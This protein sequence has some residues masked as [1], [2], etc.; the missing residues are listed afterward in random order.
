MNNETSQYKDT[1]SQ[2]HDSLDRMEKRTKWRNRGENILGISL[3]VVV[4]ILC[5]IGQIAM[6]Q[7]RDEKEALKQDNAMLRQ[8]IKSHEI[9]FQ[10]PKP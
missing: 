4:L 7:S 8:V 10:Q 6:K 9:Q 3:V 5:A 1:L 2:I